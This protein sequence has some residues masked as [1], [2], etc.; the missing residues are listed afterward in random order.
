MTQTKPFSL[1]KLASTLATLSLCSAFTLHAN[2]Q[3]D[4]TNT[5]NTDEME[6]IVVTAAG[7]EQYLSQAAASISVIDRTDIEK[8]FYK[9]LTDALRDV[10]GVTLTRGGASEDVS[11][12]GMN[13]QYTAILVDG[14]KQ[15]GRETQPSGSGAGWEQDWLPPLDA[16]ERIE[17]VRG[18]MATLYGSG[19]IGGVINIITRKD[20][21]KFQG[22]VRLETIVQEDSDA[23]DEKQ[24]QVYLAMPIVKDLLSGSFTAMTQER[25]E[26][27]I[28]D[29][30]GGKEMENYRAE[31]H[32]MPTKSDR[33]T[34]D[35]AKQDQKRYT[36]ESKSVESARRESERN[37]NRE[38]FSLSHNGNYEWA[39]GTS[40][41]QQETVE[42]VGREIT[43]ENLVFNSQWS[44]TFDQNAIVAG[45]S[46]E[47]EDLE[48]FGNGAEATQISNYQ[49]ALFADNEWQAKDDLAITFGLRYDDN[50]IF[51][52]HVSYRLYGVW[53]L[54][55][56]WVLKGGVSTG[57]SAPKIR[58]MTPEWVQ[59]SRGGDIYGNPDLKPETSS[60]N[61]L[62]IYYTGDNNLVAQVTAFYN[63][64]ED[65]TNLT[66][67]PVEKCGGPTGR[68][69][70]NLDEATVS[71]VEASINT[72]I[73]DSL[74]LNAAY[75]Y[76]D[77]E[78]KSGD[79][80]GQPLT[81]VPMH[82]TNAGANWQVS[83]SFSTWAKVTYR[84][85]DSQP[86]TIGSRS[87]VAKSLTYMDIGVNWQINDMFTLSTGVYN[88]FDKEVTAE[89]YGYKEDGR[90]LWLSVVASF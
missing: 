16:I 21:E 60:N 10:P 50:E 9:D 66:T 59:E 24:A 47:S 12:R 14:K 23:G 4:D 67:C 53:S 82:L 75:T 26:D 27:K 17:V 64:F 39:T 1:S 13:G 80:K 7:R 31:L 54:S 37:S 74:S 72:D 65:K 63:D 30:Y 52:S 32:F 42:N 68:Q 81:Q 8:G 51:D 29:G 88:L 76:S 85:K 57:Y 18:P 3:A 78:Q 41:V 48:D 43:I 84:G 86:I 22:S 61:E 38:S 25:D 49:W 46:Y 79:N 87:T 20:F 40:F 5:A 28:I 2:A 70:E 33:F 34:L 15:S 36:T 45:V 6:T 73:T 11:L 35:Y 55:D 58:A 89:E 77:S 62:G 90:R 44:T 71:G 83:E 69:Y 19:A 56:N